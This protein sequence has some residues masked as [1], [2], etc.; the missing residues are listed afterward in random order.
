MQVGQQG[1]PGFEA[2]N[3]AAAQIPPG[4]EGLL[5]CDHF[6]GNRTP[7]TNAASRGAFVGLTLK[8]NQAHVFRA[9]MEGVAF[10]TELIL[11]NMRDAGY[12]PES[13]TL[14]GESSIQELPV[15]EG[16]SAIGACFNSLA[17]A[18]SQISVSAVQP[19]LCLHDSVLVVQT[20]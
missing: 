7:Y 13:L 11:E 3:T 10:G 4:S 2:L 14:A 12:H 8:H 19:L 6:Q 16:I 1:W 15:T 18:A 9:I 20:V 17:A 5:C